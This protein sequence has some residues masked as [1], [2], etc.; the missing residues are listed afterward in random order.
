MELEEEHLASQTDK[1]E[2]LETQQDEQLPRLLVQRHF[3][4]SS[5]IE[6]TV[7]PQDEEEETTGLLI[8]QDDMVADAS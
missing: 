4:F 2:L 7:E 5:N 3:H 1:L 6:L 8:L